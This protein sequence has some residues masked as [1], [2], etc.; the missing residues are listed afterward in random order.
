MFNAS[1]ITMG[2]KWNNSNIIQDLEKEIGPESTLYWL[3][4]SICGAIVWTVYLTY[5][6]SRVLGLIL[7]AVINRFVPHGHVKFGTYA[8]LNLFN[9]S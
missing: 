2:T 8:L 9:S 3:L 1:T 5:Y 7:T 4:I 6:N